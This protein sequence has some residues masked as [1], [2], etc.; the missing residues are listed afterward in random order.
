MAKKLK[1]YNV[2]G[3][4]VREISAPSCLD[5]EINQPLVSKYVR[6]L[7]QKDRESIAN[8]KNRGQVS[9]GGRKPWKQKGTGNARVGSNRSPIWIGGGVTFGPTNEKTYTVRMNAKERKQALLMTIADK[10]EKTVV[11]DDLKLKE[12]KTKNGLEV[13]NKLPVAEGK[14]LM[15]FTEITPEN[16]LAFRNLPFVNLAKVSNLNSLEIL[17]HQSL[18]FEESALLEL[19][20]IYKNV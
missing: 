17:K 13:L 10:L 19:A 15:L 11:I 5:I 14:I 7:L 2:K 6:Y 20:N 1:V 8:T 3:E 12:V 9:G 18:L 16:S 4:V